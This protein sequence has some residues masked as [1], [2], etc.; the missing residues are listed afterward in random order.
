MNSK[1]HSPP[2]SGP[3][4]L[5]VNIAWSFAGSAMLAL[6]QWA[7]LAILARYE[8][9][10][11][12]G[13]F[14]FSMAITGPIVIFSQL[15]LNNYQATDARRD[16]SFSEYL[17]LRL[18]TTIV[19][20]LVIFLVAVSIGKSETLTLPILLA[21][22]IR[23]LDAIS[24]VCHGRFMQQEQIDRMGIALAAK[25]VAGIVATGLIIGTG[26]TVIG[27]LCGVIAVRMIVMLLWEL[28]SVA[29]SAADI[30]DVC[31]SFSAYRLRRLA[32]QSL[33]LGVVMLIISLRTSVPQ[34][35]LEHRLGLEAVGAFAS[36]LALAQVGNLIVTA[37][38]RAASPRL[39]SY[40]IRGQE[41]QF[42]ALVLKSIGLGF[43]LACL[44]L[45]GAATFGSQVLK[46]VYG[47]EFA[48]Y[49]LV[50]TVVAFA[51]GFQFV[52]APLGVAA[53]A[54][55]KIRMQPAIHLVN[56]GM[57]A[58]TCWWSVSFGLIGIAWALVGSASFNMC[59]YTL[60][61]LF[62]KSD[63]RGMN[64]QALA[65]PRS[66]SPHFHGTFASCSHSNAAE[67]AKST[68]TP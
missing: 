30:G 52:S 4:S 15:S 62:S 3:L 25:S 39:S 13:V 28:P 49:G 24:D 63:I 11:A 33:P 43:A 32:I 64:G 19:A 60:L 42:N 67:L 37:I 20:M 65:A 10:A 23:G 56:L 36:I 40:W 27:V 48:Q 22:A 44:G 35:L 31:P 17:G 12:A 7:M 29:K 53:T 46:I 14:A 34:Y 61:L 66:A 68:V 58:L 26:G 57:L 9:M 59:A 38:S 41:K 55:R 50:L 54:S 21:G 51:A 8:S 5:R 1:F 6:H 47:P 16:F 2:A 45:I 18:L